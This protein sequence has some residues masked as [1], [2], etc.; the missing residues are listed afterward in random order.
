[1]T[2]YTDSAAVAADVAARLGAISVANGYETDIGLKTYRGR[3]KIPA[4]DEVP[5]LFV[6][7][8]FDRPQEQGQSGLVR[9][10]LPV[11]VWGFNVCDPD[12]PNDAAHAMLRDIK[13]AVWGGVPNLGGK[14]RQVIYESR[15]IG[16]RPDGAA[17]VQV[18]LRF[19]VEFV[20][21]L[22]PS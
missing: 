14:A 11:V 3:I 2:V 17:L 8:G 7:E 4:D 10:H 9:L 13:K 19:V 22:R 16:P 21:N 18:E 15:D 12:N 5:C 20:E 1:M 6:I